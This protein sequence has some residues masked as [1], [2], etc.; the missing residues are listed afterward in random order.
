MPNNSPS[1]LPPV[2]F[3]KLALTAMFWALLLAPAWA[4]SPDET[5]IALLDEFLAG[6][7]SNDIAAHQRFWSDDLVY[8]SSTGERYGKAEI[9]NSMQDAG[10]AESGEPAMV[11][12]RE[13]LLVR[14]YGDAAVVTF[15]LT[16]T[17]QSDPA[18]VV[19]FYNTGTFLLRD[20]EWR[21]IAWQATRIPDEPDEA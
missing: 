11:Y 18:S 21:A 17:R 4:A 3:R 15:R 8:T 6:A 1:S 5:L 20:G 10:A 7:S 14:V 2:I 16:G 19:Q 9:I 12:G 13:A